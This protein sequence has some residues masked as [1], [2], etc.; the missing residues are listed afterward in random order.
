M[1]FSDH[2]ISGPKRKLFLAGCV[3]LL[4]AVYW[5]SAADNPA[6]LPAEAANISCSDA[7]ADREPWKID[8]QVLGWKMDRGGTVNVN[9]ERLRTVVSSGH[10]ACESAVLSGSIARGDYDKVAAL[11]RTSLPLLYAFDL[12]SPGGDVEEALKIGRL[13]RKYLIFATALSTVGSSV[14]DS[15]C[16]SACA[17]IWLGAVYRLGNVGVHRLRIEGAEFKALSPADA[18]KFYRQATARVTTYLDEMEVPPSIIETMVATG[19]TTIRW[20][21]AGDGLRDVPSIEE[22]QQASCGSD[23]VCRTKLLLARR[24]R[25]TPP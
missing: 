9:P 19:S 3:A 5:F 21:F 18:S 2:E 24:G 8:W 1:S 16:A 10:I 25:L 7:V 22:W 23:G 13:F 15:P 11:F 4:A 20:I 17:L 14:T 6:G 12:R